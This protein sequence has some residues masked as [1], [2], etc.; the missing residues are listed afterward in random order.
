MENPFRKIY[1]L[2]DRAL[3]FAQAVKLFIRKLPVDMINAEYS[4]QVIRSSSAIGANY[5]EAN[6]SL[7]KKDFSMRTKIAKKEAKETIFWLK[8][9][10]S[11]LAEKQLLTN[12]AQELMNILGSMIDKKEKKISQT[13]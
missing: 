7:G 9:I 2:E 3:A 4:K 11:E 12:E 8:L 10:D 1:N 13:P 5:I 6:N